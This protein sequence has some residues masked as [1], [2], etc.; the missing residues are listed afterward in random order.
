MTTPGVQ[1]SEFTGGA[2]SYIAPASRLH[3][4]RLGRY[5]SIRDR[6]ITLSQ[7]P[8]HALTTSPITYSPTFPPPFDSQPHFNFP[9][10]QKTTI[11]ND[12]WIGTGTLIKSGVSIGDGAI[13]GAGS[14]VTKDV[15]P[16]SIVGGSPAKL[17]RMRFSDDIIERIQ[18]LRRWQYNIQHLPLDFENPTAALDVASL[19]ISKRSSIRV[20]CSPLK[21]HISRCKLKTNN[22][23]FCQ[24]RRRHNSLLDETHK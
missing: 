22:I 18:R 4:V 12:A 3:H 11:G 9:D 19:T 1:L 13:I 6:V 15:P 21:I 8:T 5:C 16:F 2:F 17:L 14:V 10:W 20:P 23:L 7:H 24:P